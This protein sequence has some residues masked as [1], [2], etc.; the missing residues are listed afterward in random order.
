MGPEGKGQGRPRPVRRTHQTGPRV[1][2]KVLWCQAP[3]KAL[4]NTGS[5]SA[6]ELQVDGTP[7]PLSGPAQPSH[8]SGWG[9]TDKMGRPALQ[10]VH[11][12]RHSKWLSHWMVL[13][14]EGANQ[15]LGC[16]DGAG[17]RLRPARATGHPAQQKCPEQLPMGAHGGA[18]PWPSFWLVC[19]QKTVMSQKCK[20]LRGQCCLLVLSQCGPHWQ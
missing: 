18:W 2:L 14:R 9:Q 10:C 13:E 5:S 6:D 16:L 4:L 1:H 7:S 17:L 11:S 3:R 12:W 8:C 19:T 20:H 15:L